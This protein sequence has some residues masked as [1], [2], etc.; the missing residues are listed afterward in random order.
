MNINIREIDDQAGARIKAAAG[1]R[2][3]TIGEYVAALVKLHDATRAR[4]DAGDEGADTDL[5]VL[6]LQTVTT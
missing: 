1:A 5:K 4:A 2:G 6:G 3:M